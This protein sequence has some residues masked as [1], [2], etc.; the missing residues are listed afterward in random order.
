MNACESP[1]PP[2]A[3]RRRPSP[4]VY[5]ALKMRQAIYGSDNDHI[6]IA[7]NVGQLGQ[8][9]RSRGPSRGSPRAAALVRS[10]PVVWNHRA[11]AVARPCAL[12]PHGRSPLS[13][14]THARS[15]ASRAQ[16]A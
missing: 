14:P 10:R 12:A 7:L 11:A 13:G 3:A 8:L 5:Q 2:V 6:E 9:E 1:S 15:D 4:A 16:C